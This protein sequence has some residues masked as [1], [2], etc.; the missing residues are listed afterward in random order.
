MYQIFIVL[1]KYGNSILRGGQLG[2]LIRETVVGELLKV[3]YYLFAFDGAISRRSG[4]LGVFT[5]LHRAL[6]EPVP[7][8]QE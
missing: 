8:I 4:N 3:T 5:P 6:R 7:A 1:V 2:L